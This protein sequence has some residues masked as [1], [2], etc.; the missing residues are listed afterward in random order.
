MGVARNEALLFEVRAQLGEAFTAEV[1]VVADLELPGSVDVRDSNQDTRA[2]R[3]Y[4][5]AVARLLDQTWDNFSTN[6]NV[7]MHQVF[8]FARESLTAS[9]ASP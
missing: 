7:D 6:W 9:L 2:Q 3:R 5:P 1:A 4:D 8:N